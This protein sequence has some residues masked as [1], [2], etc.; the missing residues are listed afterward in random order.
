LYQDGVIRV[1]GLTYKFAV[2]VSGKSTDTTV[3]TF[4]MTMNGKPIS[5]ASVE[6]SNIYF[7]RYSDTAFEGI[8]RRSL[9][10]KL[11]YDA[12]SGMTTS[13]LAELAGPKAR[14]YVDYTDLSKDNGILVCTA[15]ISRS[16]VCRCVSS[17]FNSRMQPCRKLARLIT[18]LPPTTMAARNATR[19]PTSSMATSTRPG[20]S[21]LP[22]RLHGCKVCHSDDAAGHFEWP[23]S[24][25]NPE[26]AAN[27]AAGAGTALTDAQ[28][29][30]YAYKTRL[31]NDV[32]LSHAVEFPYPQS[33]SSCVT[34]HEG[35]L[36][37]ILTDT[38]FN[39]ATCKSCHPVTGAV[40]KDGDTVIYDTTKLALKTNLPP[41]SHGSMD[42]EKTDCT[43]C[44]GEGK[45][46]PAFNKIHTGMIR[47]S[48][49]STVR[50]SRILS[51]SASTKPLSKIIN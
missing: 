23:L 11:T 1:T 12:A 4:K 51:L 21:G 2:G 14:G 49:P 29:A 46:A 27:Y 17:R 25:G 6:N 43:S 3:V 26:L 42:L 8:D 38:N 35:K 37:K 18:S 15:M 7:A 20:R 24:M 33:M 22:N 40:K 13:T 34:C 44:H 16:A 32:H 28:T 31:M 9:K 36:D 41:V 30:Q 39:I 5:G 48:T 50:I 19:T 47:R 10:G 45:A